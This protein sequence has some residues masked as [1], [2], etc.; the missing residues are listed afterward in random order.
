MIDKLPKYIISSIQNNHTSL[1]EHPALPPDDEDMFL[2][3]IVNS[4]FNYLVKDVD[5]DSIDSLKNELG[6][7]LSEC[8]KIEKDNKEALERLVLDVVNDLF[9]I[10][11]DTL[12]IDV[13][14]VSNISSKDQ[15]LIPEKTDDFEFDSIED[16]NGLSDEIYK[17]RMLN[18]LVAG[19]SA[20]G[21]SDINEYLVRLFNISPSLP[22]LYVKIMTY[23]NILMFFEKDTLSNEAST[24]ASKVD[25]F[26]EYEKNK[27]RIMA[28]GIIFPTLL[29]ETIKGLNELAISHGLPKDRKKAEYVIKK[30][31]FKLAEVWDLRLGIPLWTQILKCFEKIG[32][33]VNGTVMIFFLMTLSCLPVNEFNSTLGEILANTKKGCEMLRGMMKE[34]N[35]NL[36]TD[37]FNDYMISQQNNMS[38]LSDSDYFEPDELIIDSI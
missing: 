10:P 4:Y 31:D 15:R 17:R 20:C 5:V 8:V 26:I 36:E 9:R 2:L 3:K 25:V 23:N 28:E 24:D 18:A 35:H 19:A 33:D 7:L 6:K 22:A 38:Q 27:V 29:I 13:K 1:G 14:L 37:D 11:S 30:A 21:A 34:I 16:M 12:T 32:E